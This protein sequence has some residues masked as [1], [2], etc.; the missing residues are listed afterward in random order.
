L[1]KKITRA[2]VSKDE[3]DGMTD[4]TAHK[5]IAIRHN[6]DDCHRRFLKQLTGWAVVIS[7]MLSC[8]SPVLNCRSSWTIDAM[9]TTGRRQIPMPPQRGD[10]APFPELFSAIVERFRHP[11][12][13]EHKLILRT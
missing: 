4:A 9:T 5:D 3:L 11:V 2:V 1:L 10:R 7:V 8:C 12:G 13:A 6:D